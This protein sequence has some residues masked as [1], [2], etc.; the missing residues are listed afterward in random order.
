MCHPDTIEGAVLDHLRSRLQRA[1]D[2]LDRP[3]NDGDIAAAIFEGASI[4]SGCAD[5]RVSC[6]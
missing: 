2:A 4:E 6:D 3:I 1:E 5:I